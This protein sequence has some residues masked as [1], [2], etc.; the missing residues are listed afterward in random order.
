M[1]NKLVHK[2]LF[3]TWSNNITSQ[4]IQEGIL[5]MEESTQEDAF[6]KVQR[7]MDSMWVE[8]LETKVTG[9]VMSPTFNI[10]A[11]GAIIENT[12]AWSNIRTHLAGRKYLVLPRHG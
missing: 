9:G 1:S 3:N 4:F 8:P 7:F 5:A 6:Q 12:H 10:F 11:Q 2:Y